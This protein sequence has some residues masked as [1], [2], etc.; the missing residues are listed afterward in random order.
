MD[1]DAYILNY[2]DTINRGGLIYP[3]EFLFNVIQCAY[4]IFNTC[5]SVHGAAF[6]KVTNQ[7]Q[8][9]LGLFVKHLTNHNYFNDKLFPCNVCIFI[10]QLLCYS[11]CFVT[12]I[13]M[14][15]NIITFV[16]PETGGISKPHS[17]I[18]FD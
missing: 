4:N 1:S 16:I 8:T 14:N 12:F 11:C 6:L 10:T 5:I 7:N 17:N 9:L 18:V 13:I 3:S 15:N 2:F